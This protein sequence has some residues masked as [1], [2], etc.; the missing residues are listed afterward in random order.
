MAQ[1]RPFLLAFA[2]SSVLHLSM[3]T[4]FTIYID[5]PVAKIGY[6]TFDIVNP[7]THLSYLGPGATDDLPQNS[8][9]ET[10]RLN[11]SDLTGVE[12]PANVS[13][14]I[15]GEF[16]AI[17][18]PTW[19]LP[20][21][22]RLQLRQESLRLRAEF[23]RKQKQKPLSFLLGES[24][25]LRETLGRIA[26]FGDDDEAPAQNSAM[27]VG[28]PV[29]GV[30]MYIEWMADPKDREILYSPPIESLW[31]LGPSAL[32]QPMSILFKV[33][34]SG[35]VIEVL[36]PIEEDNE[37]AGSAGKALLKYRFAPLLEGEDKEQ[38]GTLLVA[39][40]AKETP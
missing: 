5:I 12:A 17:T 7:A 34:A 18:L 3:V 4:I 28:R 24:G 40:E 6:Y 19:A 14:G 1:N 22:E 26:D 31:R 16:P 35:E 37:L 27:L 38:Y 36:T 15:T 33:A 30:V 13:E 21:L 32:R 11:A 9:R 2:F 39:P 29:E 25:F 10:L 8:L 23:V 20:E